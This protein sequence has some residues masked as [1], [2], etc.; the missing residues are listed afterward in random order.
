[1]L[2][3]TQLE[4]REALKRLSPEAQEILFSLE[5]RPKMLALAKKFLIPD[6]QVESFTDILD[7]AL[8]GLVTLNDLA[9]ALQAELGMKAVVATDVVGSFLSDVAVPSKVTPPASDSVVSQTL[10]P[11]D[12]SLQ[13]VIEG[14]EAISKRLGDLPVRVQQVILSPEVSIGVTRLLA[15]AHIPQAKTSD[16]IR[17]IALIVVGLSQITA[18]ETFMVGNSMLDEIARKRIVQSVTESVFAPV[19]QA[20]MTAL[21]QKNPNTPVAPPAPEPVATPVVAP[22]TPFDP[23]HENL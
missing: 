10:P 2:T 18:L 12:V 17:Q 5:T 14:D 15:D 13:S 9:S 23:Y 1:M 11:K 7:Y 3:F 4:F 20:L 6:A 22:A 19:R 8:F 16:C 21:T